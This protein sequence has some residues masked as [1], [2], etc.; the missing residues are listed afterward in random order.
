M[1]DLTF[2]SRL[3]RPT[4]KFLADVA[5]ATQQCPCC[6]RPWAS[7][8]PRTDVVP[9]SVR[10]GGIAYKSADSGDGAAAATGPADATE[11]LRVSQIDPGSLKMALLVRTDL[12]MTAGKVAVQ[13]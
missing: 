10:R 4:A 9:R 6:P 3:Y 5:A 13:C 12:K 1:F 8:K 7:T 11:E 2:H